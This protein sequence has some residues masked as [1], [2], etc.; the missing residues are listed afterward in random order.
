M[1]DTCFPRSPGVGPLVIPKSPLSIWHPASVCMVHKSRMCISLCKVIFMITWYKG[2]TTGRVPSFE[3]RLT[4][5][6]AVPRPKY[7]SLQVK[8][9]RGT[10]RL[11]ALFPVHSVIPEGLLQAL[12]LLFILL[13]RS[14]DPARISAQLS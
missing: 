6:P 1:L 4:G 12:S 10:H 9:L 3:F 13:K 5:C 11:V 2:R 8:R 14:L 7:P